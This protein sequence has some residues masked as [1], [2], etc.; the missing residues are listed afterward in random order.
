MGGPLQHWGEILK[1][2]FRCGSNRKETSQ[3]FCVGLMSEMQSVDIPIF[4]N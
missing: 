3:R 1:R 4:K 2:V